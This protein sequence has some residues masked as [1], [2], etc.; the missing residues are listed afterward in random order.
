[1][2]KVSF[3]GRALEEARYY[4]WDLQRAVKGQKGAIWWSTLA[5]ELTSREMRRP[6]FIRDSGLPPCL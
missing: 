5:T 1:M 6:V 3:P 2:W 4:S